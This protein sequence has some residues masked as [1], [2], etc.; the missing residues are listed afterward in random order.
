MALL[1]IAVGAIGRLALWNVPNV[2]TV[3]VVSLLAGMLLSGLYV[4]LVPIVVMAMT[5]V[6]GYALGWTGAYAPWQVIGLAGF[7]YSG[8]LFV[9]VL[10]R[11][12]RPRLL[13]RT[14]TIAVMTSISIPAT[15]LFDL[16]TA[17]GDW[18]LITSR[19]PFG[20]SFQQ[21]LQ[22]QVPFTLVHIASSLLF[23]PLFGMMFLYLH[24]HGWPAVQ[25]AARSVERRGSA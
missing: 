15:V 7:V 25:P 10:G 21:V 2:E 20:W 1:L 18:L 22:F 4:L 12:M 16:W 6:V 24:T 8:F 23:V 19:P 9:T 14:R 13:F 17:F 3:L 11:V 5:D